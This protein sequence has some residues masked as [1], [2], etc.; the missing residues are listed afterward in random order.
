MNATISAE[1]PVRYSERPEIGRDFLE[2]N[3]PEGWDDVKKLSKKV[4]KYNGRSFTFTGWNSDR[5]VCY[6]FAPHG[7]SQNVA[8]F[9]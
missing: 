4:L 9:S 6:F 8:K 5:L 3:V 1:I 7:G 2:I